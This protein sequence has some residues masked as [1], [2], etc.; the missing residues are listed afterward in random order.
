MIGQKLILPTGVQAEIDEIAELYTPVYGVPFPP[1][2]NVP[3]YI[4]LCI[5]YPTFCV[6]H[7]SCTRDSTFLHPTFNFDLCN[8]QV[9][10]FDI[11][12]F[13]SSSQVFEFDLQVQWD[14]HS[15]F[16]IQHLAFVL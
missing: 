1:K 6:C 3:F 14:A 16:R 10:A 2:F 11:Q 12:L 13:I 9:F 5:L 8:I 4:V 15:L 7:L